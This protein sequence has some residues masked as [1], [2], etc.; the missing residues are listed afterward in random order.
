M[1]PMGMLFPMF[2]PRRLDVDSWILLLQLATLHPKQTNPPI[3]CSLNPN[4][5]TILN[6]HQSSAINYSI[7]HI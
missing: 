2:D 1:E 3:C 5:N 6:T 7:L 4:K